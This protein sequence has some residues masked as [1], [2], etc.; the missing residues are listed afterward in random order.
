MEVRQ[1]R[2]SLER[3]SFPGLGR[4]GREV[5]LVCQFKACRVQPVTWPLPTQTCVGH[6]Q[7]ATWRILEP[8]AI[9]LFQTPTLVSNRLLYFLKICSK[10]S[11]L[12]SSRY[13]S[14]IVSNKQFF[15]ITVGRRPIACCCFG[16]TAHKDLYNLSHF[17]TNPVL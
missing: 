6:F 7:R 13:S 8:P 15:Q 10:S 5:Y 3:N 1:G 17:K 4:K 2:K 16:S 14:Y 11:K 12:F 9:F